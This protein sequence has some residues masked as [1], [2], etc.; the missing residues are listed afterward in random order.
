MDLDDYDDPGAV[1][2]GNIMDKKATKKNTNNTARK[3]TGNK[4]NKQ[5][6]K[7]KKDKKIKKHK[8][9]MANKTSKMKETG[10]AD[11]KNKTDVG[12][13]SE[14]TKQNSNKDMPCKKKATT[15]Q[16][17]TFADKVWKRAR[18][19][20][21]PPAQ[22][23]DARIRVGSDCCGYCS[24]HIALSLLGVESVLVFVSEKDAGKRELL[25]AANPNVNFAETILYHDITKRNNEDAPY[26]DLFV[27]GAPCQPWSTAGEQNGLDDLRGLVIFHSLEYVRCKRP[28]AVVFEN[29]KGLTMGENKKN[30]EKII[31]ILKDLGY[32]VE[33][34]IL[35]TR[36]HGVPQSRPRVY[37]VAIRARHIEQSFSFPSALRRCTALANYLHVDDVASAACPTTKCFKAAMAKA[38]AKYGKKVDERFVVVDVSASEKYASAMLDC[39]PCITKSRGK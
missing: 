9:D 36:D 17:S 7:I 1:V 12:N 2:P 35:D 34:R 33:W 15:V 28:R 27:S 20:E 11:K 16:G 30:F 29:V 31:N 4:V 23:L 18:R 26:V 39:C 5:H 3:G 13:K 6:K 21:S 19:A 24:D 10:K 37:I 14:G 38:E 22:D 32:A 25:K 8:K